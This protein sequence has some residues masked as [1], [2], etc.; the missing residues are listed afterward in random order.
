M[1]PTRQRSELLALLERV[2]GFL[3]AQQLHARLQRAGSS[4]G[5]ATVY[6]NLAALTEQ[7]LVDTVSGVGGEV[8]YRACSTT[9]HHH[10]SCT[11]CGKTVE[12]VLE[13]LERVCAEVAQRNGFSD[14][15]HTVEI[16][17]T[18]ADCARR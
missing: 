11:G 15:R 13:D 12:L 16:S 14:I 2:D 3:T 17:G 4:I 10:L 18:C 9:H 8:R 6:R 7:G 5:L 1:R